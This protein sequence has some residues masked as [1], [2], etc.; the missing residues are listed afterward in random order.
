MNPRHL[1]PLSP[2]RSGLLLLLLLAACQDAPSTGPDV[3]RPSFD[4]SEAR[5]GGGNPDL[6]FSPPLAPT[7]APGDPGFDPGAANGALRPY[8]RV[9]KTDGAESAAGCTQDVTQA[10]TGSASGLVMTYN[11]GG[12]VYQANWSTRDLDEAFDYRI[13]IWGVGF[14][15]QDERN[16]LLAITFPA[17]DPMAGRP[18]WLFGWLDVRNSPSVSSCHGTAEFCLIN[19]GQTIPVKVRIE[20]YVLCPATRNCAVQFVGAGVDANLEAVLEGELASSVQLFIPGQ[21]GTDF[22]LGF[23]PCT[24]AEKAAAQAYAAIPTFGPCLKTVTAGD[25]VALGEP[26]VLSFCIDINQAEIEAQLAFP[27]TQH[28]LVGVHHFSTGGDP[29]GAIQSVEAWPHVA[30]MCDQPTSGGLASNDEPQ[31]FVQ[32][33]QAAGKRLLSLFNPEPVLALDLGGGGEGFKLWSYY[34]LGLPTKFEYENPTDSQQRG[35]A[36]APHT[37]RAKATDL[38]G[39]P[40]WNARVDWSV[41]SSPGGASVSTS[42]VM[43]GL[44]G[45]AQAA[46]TL[47]PNEGYNVFH[48]GGRGIAD[49]RE[50][51]C[52]LFGGTAGAAS[53]NGPRTTYDPFQ[54]HT[55]AVLGGVQVIPEG[56]FLPFSVYGCRQGRGT[57]TVNGVLSAGEWDCA[58]STTFPVSLSG[59][60]V[61]ATLYWMNDGTNFH[62]AVRVPGSFRENALRIDWDSDGDAPSA[63][64]QG[65]SYTTAREAGDDVWEFV[66]SSGAVD[67]FIDVG[68][69]GSSQSGC[70]SADSGF[71]GAMQTVAAFN[72]TLGGATVYE[73]SH[74]LS[75]SDVCTNAD[76]RKGCGALLGKRIDLLAATGNARGFFVTLRNGSGAQGNT[77]WPG[78]LRFMKVVIQ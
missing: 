47:S 58:N 8:L 60:A 40:V 37:L 7:P 18:R 32:L 78:F 75:T 67:R 31:G 34:M 26:A 41:F 45:I 61:Q 29:S 73:L 11:A 30:P 56:T 51:G 25:F 13:E 69:S 76:P 6:F 4:I 28:H 19:Y 39:D 15:T 53:C 36:G 70:G 50:S 9:C 2:K 59:G 27:E 65:A 48:A 43:T 54:P 63:L 66:P 16:E 21:S 46:V 23:E 64:A 52:T 17:G 12:E 77:Q 72:N 68:C 44:D 62:V 10:V 14:Q 42:S 5:F 1:L 22:P 57:P 24:A 49:P 35:V 74:P 55:G 20:D 33:A 3:G 38:N 71:G